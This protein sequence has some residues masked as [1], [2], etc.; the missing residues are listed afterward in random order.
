MTKEQKAKCKQIFQHY[1]V[2]AQE[3]QL[4]E[5]CAELIQALTKYERKFE[6]GRP[7]AEEK[8]NVMEELADVMI[9]CEQFAGS[10]FKEQ[11]L[12]A[13]IDRKLERQMQRIRS[14]KK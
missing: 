14:E 5:E 13:M 4:I 10:W 7:A 2:H 11:P 6:T 1:D 9:M 8:V 12:N 3:R